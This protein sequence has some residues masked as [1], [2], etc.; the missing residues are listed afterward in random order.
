MRRWSTVAS[1]RLRPS[2]RQH[3]GRD[4]ARAAIDFKHLVDPGRLL[5]VECL[6]DALDR[7]RDSGEPQAALEERLDRDF[8]GGVQ[9]GTGRAPVAQR[10][11]G[12]PEAGKTPEIRRLERQ[13]PQAAEVQA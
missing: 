7:R 5:R 10:L 4:L 9:Y 1:L 6:E 8:V 3:A 2:V 11:V 12:E 13:F